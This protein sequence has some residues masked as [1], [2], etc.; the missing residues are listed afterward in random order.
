[1]NSFVF[2]AANET[3]TERLG[4][5][6]ARSLPGGT[7]VALL[8]TLGAGKTRLVQ[9]FAA[10]QGVPR[11][12]ATSPTF[13]LVN[14][15]NGTRPIYHIDAYRLRDEDEFMELGPEEYFES[16]GVTFIEWADRVAGCLPP[17][18]LQIICEA[19]GETSRQFT[20]CA[21]SPRLQEVVTAVRDALGAS[22]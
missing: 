14:E 18:R 1:M 4:A 2:I 9:A 17:D 11:A 22:T 19:V 6:L 21:T 20:L 16:A 10:A 5:A 13:V 7:V 12:A 15:Y 3:D 8:G